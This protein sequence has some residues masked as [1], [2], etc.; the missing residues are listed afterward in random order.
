MIKRI[1]FFSLP[2]ETDGEK[3]WNYHLKEHAPDVIKAAGPGLIKYTI[4]RIIKDISGESKISGIVETWWESE[5]AM[6][7]AIRSPE[8]KRINI[9]W[10]EQVTNH[11]SVLVDET[12]IIS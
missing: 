1:G 2:E 6:I 3:Y 11:F 8:F 7:E 12:I 4:N 9:E 5:E 10:H